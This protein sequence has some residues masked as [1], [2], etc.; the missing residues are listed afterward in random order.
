MSDLFKRMCKMSCNL[1]KI[2][3]ETKDNEERLKLWA[4]FVQIT[5]QIN[6]LPHIQFDESED[7]YWETVEKI[8]DTERVFNEFIEH[9]EELTYVFHQLSEIIA[10]VDRI[11]LTWK[12]EN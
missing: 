4:R 9:E 12:L 11:L 6:I 1:V 10:N 7:F 5:E 3:D 8:K 2:I